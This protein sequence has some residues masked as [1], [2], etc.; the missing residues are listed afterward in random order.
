LEGTI[1][2][3]IADFGLLGV[4]TEFQIIEGGRIGSVIENLKSK[5]ENG[6]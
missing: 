2:F 1:E 5:I 6:K 3:S 4:Q